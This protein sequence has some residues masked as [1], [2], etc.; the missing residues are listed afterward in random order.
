MKVIPISGVIG[1][2]IYPKDIRAMLEAAAGEEVE[3]QISSPGGFVFEGL[4]MFNLIRRYAGAKTTF[5]MGE[6]SSMAR[7][8]LG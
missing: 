3:I 1:W 2:D 8:S 6:A 7:I 5:I 4:E